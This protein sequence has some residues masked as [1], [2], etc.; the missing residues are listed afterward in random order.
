MDRT[1]TDPVSGMSERTFIDRRFNDPIKDPASQIPWDRLAAVATKYR[2]VFEEV[3]ETLRQ[4]GYREVVHVLPEALLRGPEVFWVLDLRDPGTIAVLGSLRTAGRVQGLCLTGTSK[5]AGT[6]EVLRLGARMMLVLP[7]VE[8]PTQQERNPADVKLTARM[9]QVYQGVAD[10]MTYTEMAAALGIKRHT[11]SGH[12][13][14][15]TRRMGAAN[16]AHG[17]LLAMRAGFIH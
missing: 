12:M 7:S 5:L 6:K 15:A 11:V 10:G 16:V 17:V 3:S 2:A 4:L 14:G 13:I 1:S 9:R 8:D